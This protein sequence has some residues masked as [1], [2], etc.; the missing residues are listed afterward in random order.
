MRV[1]ILWITIYFLSAAYMA[2]NIFISNDMTD[3]NATANATAGTAV[4]T[5]GMSSPRQKSALKR[6]RGPGAS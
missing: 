3:T 4:R 1:S 2:R 5:G 6:R